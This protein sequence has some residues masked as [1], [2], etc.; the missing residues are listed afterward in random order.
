MAEEL[1]QTLIR[2]NDIERAKLV[3]EIVRNSDMTFG[4]WPDDDEADGFGVQIIKGEAIMPPLEA[5]ET[6][7]EF[8][9]VAIPCV[10]LEQALAARDKWGRLEEPDDETPEA[11]IAAKSALA[12]AEAARLVWG[13]FAERRIKARL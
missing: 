3:T 9:V 11:Q 7:D 8:S 2:L 5:F 1:R 12:L 6:D 4:V 10:G 13:C